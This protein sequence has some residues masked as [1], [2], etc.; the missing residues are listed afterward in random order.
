MR[1]TLGLLLIL[2]TICGGSSSAQSVGASVQGT[3]TDSNAAAIA[4]AKVTV[5]NTGTGASREIEADDR[6]RYHTPLLP[7]GEYEIQISASGFETSKRAGITL[8]VGQDLVLDVALSPG[9]MSAQVMVIADTTGI[10]TTSAAISGLV[11]D[12]Q[13]R[14]LPLNGRSFQQLALLQP[15]VTPALAAG[16]DVVGGRAPKKVSYLFVAHQAADRR[17]SCIDARC[18]GNDHYLCRHASG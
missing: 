1:V 5:R 12:K 4:S 18:V 6:G 16:S 10:N 7:P 3:V 15:G 11:S 14:D 8:A 9:G 2:L 13:I 17:R